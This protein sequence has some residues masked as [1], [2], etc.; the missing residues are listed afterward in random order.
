LVALV[1]LATQFAHGAV[2]EGGYV[3]ETW[4]YQDL[5]ESAHAFPEE[6]MDQQQEQPDYPQM[7]E[8][9]RQA[10]MLSSNNQDFPLPEDLEIDLQKEPQIDDRL[11][12]D[13]VSSKQERS[14]PAQVKEEV[15][16]A[17]SET[18]EA[19]PV[20]AQKKGQNEFVSFVEPEAQKT[21]RRLVEP[22]VVQSNGQAYGSNLFLLAV[23]CVMSVGI[24]G[25]VIG[26]GMYMRRRR[27]TPDDSEYAPYAGTGPGFKKGKK[28]DKGDETLAYK[29]QL[30]HYQQAKQKII[31]GDDAP[32]M[33]ESEGEDDGVDDE[34]NFSVYE[35][36]GLA[37][38]GDLEVV[39]PNFAGQP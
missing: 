5:P 27:D 8:I 18:V 7:Q 1:V 11:T 35:C 31:C 28:G 10:S 20:V 25:T 34:N 4:Q 13:S 21:K 24:V 37:A 12:D 15:P 3:P 39:N 38:T 17:K 2:S 6:F 23:G 30:H 22:V 9:I 32:G 19:Q 33:V 36:P 16:L 26:G 29:A 14:A